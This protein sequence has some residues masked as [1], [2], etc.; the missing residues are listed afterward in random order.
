M[1][2]HL[3]ALTVIQDPA[4]SGTLG[5]FRDWLAAMVL[6]APVPQQ[7]AGEAHS[8]T[9]SP[10]ADGSNFADWPACWPSTRPPTRTSAST[11]WSC[12]SMRCRTGEVFLRRRRPAGGQCVLRAAAGVLGRA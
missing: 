8:E 1:D 6:L 3:V 10:V 11:G 9:L 2:W 5:K 4:L 7:M 12:L